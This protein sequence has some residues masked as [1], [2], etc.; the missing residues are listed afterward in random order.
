MPKGFVFCPHCHTPCQR[1][2]DSNTTPEDGL[3]KHI[4]TVHPE[5]VTK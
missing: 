3:R 4:Q 2:M 1:L 5:L